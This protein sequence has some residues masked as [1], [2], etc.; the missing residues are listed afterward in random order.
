MSEELKKE[1][2]DKKETVVEKK[3]VIVEE[4]K[5]LPEYSEIQLRAMDQGWRPEDDFDGPKEMFI[6]A[7]EFLRRGELFGKIEAQR[8]EMSELRKTLRTV[9]D[10]HSRV[11]ESEFQRALDTLKRQK[12][13]ALKEGEP[14]RVVEI[15]SQMDEVRD[16]LAETKAET[17]RERLRE[18]VR[19]ESPDPR[20]TAWVD[21]NRWYAQDQELKQF[22]DSVGI[23]YTRAHPGIDPVDVL[24]YVE[25]RVRKVY[26]DRLP[27]NPNRDK[28]N[29]VE[30]G[31]GNRS[32]GNSKKSDGDDYTMSE[33]EEKVFK[34]LQRSDPKFWTKE[35]YVGDLKSQ[36]YVKTYSS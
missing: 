12:V 30:G 34:T 4:K 29:T 23:A 3:E 32:T 11:R 10:H 8:K 20:F 17:E 35:R 31:E 5:E 1:V 2:E 9:Q 13:E 27:R 22:A 6:D 26:P 33:A 15:D 18:Q 19:S 25:G 7:A 21:K 28:A 24:K 36:S 14:E 16:A